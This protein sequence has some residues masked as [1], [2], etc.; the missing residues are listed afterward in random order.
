MLIAAPFGLL[1]VLPETVAGI[2]AFAGSSL[3]GLFTS[4]SPAFLTE[5][6]NIHNRA[7]VGLIAFATF[8]ASTLG[9][10]L[11][12]DWAPHGRSPW[13]AWC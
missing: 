11:V 10:L 5:G 8:L 4:V 6:L 12:P 9:Q 3:L 1:L 13:A 2:A 7:V